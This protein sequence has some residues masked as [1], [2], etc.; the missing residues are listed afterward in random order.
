[1]IIEG[2]VKCAV[3]R[4]QTTLL[5]RGLHTGEREGVLVKELSTVCLSNKN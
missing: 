4:P 3:V 1:M 2:N 5:R